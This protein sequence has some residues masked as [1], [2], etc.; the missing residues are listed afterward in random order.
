MRVPRP[1]KLSSRE[2]QVMRLLASGKTVKEV[3]RELS[4]AVKTTSTYRLR[5]LKKLN[6]GSIV[7]LRNYAVQNG[8]VGGTGS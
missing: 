1:A 6:L 5:I 8:L 4:I 3:A 2:D 7:E